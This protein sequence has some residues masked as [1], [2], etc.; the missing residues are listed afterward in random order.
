MS[1][2]PIYVNPETGL[3]YYYGGDYANCTVSACPI[4][5]SVYGYRPSLP[6]SSTLIALYGLFIAIQIFLGVRYKKWGFMAAMIMGCIAEI[7]GYIGRILYYNNPWQGSGF[8]IQIGMFY[9]TKPMRNANSGLSLDHSC[10]GLLLGCHLR[11][12]LPDRPLRQ[13]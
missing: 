9:V 1:D 3:T 10:T 12:P 11:S 5:L 6:F 13:P 8:I 7:I 4:E 2:Q